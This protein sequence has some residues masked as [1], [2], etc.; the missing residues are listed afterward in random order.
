M[1]VTINA[2]TSAGLIQ[3]ADTSGALQFQTNGTTKL[4]VD[5]TGVYGQLTQ[6]TVQ[7]TNSG[8]ATYYDFTGIP[9]WVKRITVVLASVTPAS[10]TMQIQLGTSSGIDSTSTY[11]SSCGR[12]G[13]TTND[14]TNSTTAFVIQGAVTNQGSGNVIITT[15]G[16]N[17]WSYTSTITAG[18]SQS[19]SNGAGTKTLSG[20]LDRIRLTTAAGNVLFTAGSVNILYEG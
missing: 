5:S 13:L 15:V 12:Q 1:A 3:S 10:S 11:I 6:G 18:S 19:L 16:S 7:V 14:F 17:I 4:T 20:T 2:S 8:S 9:S